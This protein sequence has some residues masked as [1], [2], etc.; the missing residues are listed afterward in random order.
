[1]AS[2]NTDVWHDMTSG[3][4]SSV[5]MSQG[6]ADLSQRHNCFLYLTIQVGESFSFLTLSLCFTSPSL[7]LF[8]L[9]PCYDLLLFKVH[10]HAFPFCV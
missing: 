3:P 2:E 5:S 9:P 1:M 7:P 4:V 10:M 6:F 8:L